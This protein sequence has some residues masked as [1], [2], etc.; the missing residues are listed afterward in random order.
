MKYAA[1]S[2]LD[3]LSMARFSS[4]STVF[5]STALEL[6]FCCCAANGSVR[7]STRVKAVI[8]FMMPSQCIAKPFLVG[9]ASLPAA[10]LS[11]GEKRPAIGEKRAGKDARPTENQILS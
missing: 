3:K 2:R 4:F 6:A 11:I 7:K 5:S 9:R 10:F 1:G 8:D